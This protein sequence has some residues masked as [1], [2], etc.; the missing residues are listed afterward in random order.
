MLKQICNR[1]WIVMNI[2]R[3]VYWACSDHKITKNHLSLGPKRQ[4][5]HF[6]PPGKLSFQFLQLLFHLFLEGIRDWLR[7]Q[8]DGLRIFTNL[9]GSLLEVSIPRFKQS[10]I[11]KDNSVKAF[12][13]NILKIFDLSSFSFSSQFQFKFNTC[14]SPWEL[15]NWRRQ[16]WPGELLLRNDRSK[17]I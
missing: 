15:I 9:N 11:L 4:P 8:K 7:L 17:A 10:F 2:A 5:N 12:Y 16:S 3:L 13:R 14:F 1:Q 6:G